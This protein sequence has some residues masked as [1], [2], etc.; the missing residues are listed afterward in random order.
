MVAI[1]REVSSAL[2]ECE[3]THLRRTAIDVELAR[4]QHRAYERALSDAGYAVERLASGSDMPDS[5]FVEDVAV[6]LDELAIVTRPGAPSRR[7]EVPAVADALKRH[8]RLAFIEP[9]AIVDGGDVLVCGRTVYVGRSTRTNDEAVAQIRRILAPLGYAVCAVTV[10]H[11]LHLK[12]A[13]T[14]VSAGVLLANP[15]RVDR[16]AFGASEIIDVHPGEAS[17]ANALRL[18][19]RIIFPAAF[20]W[21]AERLRARG[22]RVEIV[23]ASELQKA[24]GAVTCCSLIMSERI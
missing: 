7:V 12:S 20:P 5:V 18:H 14:E 10:R 3:L 9:P 6:V 8:R 19:D 11:C 21:T 2:A 23:D 17:A 24:E 22:L 15:D 13:V 16:A 1:T 4:A